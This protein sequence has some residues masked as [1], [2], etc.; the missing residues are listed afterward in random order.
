MII[1]LP[2]LQPGRI[3][4]S[5]AKRLLQHYR[6]KSGLS[7]DALLVRAGVGRDEGVVG[8]CLDTA[9]ASMQITGARTRFELGTQPCGYRS[10]L[11][12]DL[13]RIQS[14]A[15]LRAAH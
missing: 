10:S 15:L 5:D 1:R 6:G 9:R 2:R 7:A 4:C 11:D 3:V 8:D 12:V 14:I 13:H